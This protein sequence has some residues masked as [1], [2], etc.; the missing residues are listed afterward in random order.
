[1]GVN[2]FS[3]YDVINRNAAC[4]RER[5]AWFEVDDHRSLT[6]SEY[7][8][9][10]DCLA[11]GLQRSG[12]VKGDRIGV[13]GKNSLE[14]FL[15]YG[16][17]AALGAIMLPINWRLSP[18][19]IC[20]NINDCTPKVLFVG[21]EYQE[22]MDGLSHRLTSVEKYFC[23]G[24]QEGTC[25]GFNSLVDNHGVFEA[26][27]VSSE[28]GFVII[29]TAA[30]AG[31]PKGALLSHSNIIFSNLQMHYF[32][33][34]NLE[35]VYLNFLP[36]FHVASIGGTAA[37]F[38]AGALTVNMSKFDAEKASEVIQQKRVSVIHE[39]APVLSSIIEQSEKSG[40][41]IKSLR[42][43]IGLDEPAT[44]EKYQAIT[45]GSFYVGYGQTE[46]SSGVTFGRYSDR[47]G[48]AGRASPLTNVQIV[49]DHDVSVPIGQTGEIVTK[50][51]LVFKGYWNLPEDDKYIFRNGW[52]HTGD[53]GR[54]DEDGFLWYAGRKADKELIKPGGE[55]VYP[56]EVEKAI[57]EHPAVEMTV[58]FGVPDPKWKEGIKAVCKLK[59]G[60]TLKQHELIKFVGGCIASYKK[61]QYVEFV[62]KLPLLESGMPDREKIKEMYGGS[63]FM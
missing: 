42:A 46:N 18:D 40:T 17:S 23:L 6:F 16:A 26:A 60:Y 41:D 19:E 59:D 15:L 27:E 63:Q 10:V 9:K 21:K 54:F 25:Q 50:G 47:P 2:D 38:H 35:D 33:N 37:M 32:L 4:F 49:D 22:L 8:Q 53:L 51:P 12:L 29:H 45:E 58:V 36:L 3:F 55:N 56:V 43:V 24:T 52:Q 30:V 44:I 5:E 61:P 57:L 34:V 14:Y 1:M 48:S 20:Y 39:F 7:K 11:S 13:L 62:A 28:D 31:R